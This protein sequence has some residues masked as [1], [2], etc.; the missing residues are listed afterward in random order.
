MKEF[1]EEVKFYTL[2]VMDTLNLSDKK[3]IKTARMV[4][5]EDN[6]ITAVFDATSTEDLTHIFC[7]DV[8]LLMTHNVKGLCCFH[9]KAIKFH[10]SRI[11]FSLLKEIGTIQRRRDVKIKVDHLEINLTLLFR[12]NQTTTAQLLDISAGGMLFICPQNILM[13]REDIIYHFEFAD[14]PF[15]VKAKILRIQDHPKEGRCYGCCFEDL[16]PDEEAA[17][18]QFV[19]KLQRIERAK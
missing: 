13:E 9:A 3:L 2:D 12:N 7:D 10:H 16:S 5:K 15:D 11:T 1:N 14:K 8:V 6:Q 19:F 18:R 4:K 17:I